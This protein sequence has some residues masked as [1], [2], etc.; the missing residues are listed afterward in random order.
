MYRLQIRCRCPRTW[1]T[2][3]ARSTSCHLTP[4]ASPLRKP[5]RHIISSG[6]AADRRA[7]FKYWAT[8]SASSMATSAALC[9]GEGQVSSSS[10][11]R[12]RRPHFTATRS[13]FESI[14]LSSCAALG[15]SAATCFIQIKQCTGV[16]SH[17]SSAPSHAGTASTDRRYIS[18]VDKAKHPFPTTYTLYHV[19]S[20][21][22]TVIFAYL[23]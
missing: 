8:C 6:A 4:R 18:R 22:P 15:C 10:S 3:A 21:S 20:H 5:Q 16:S 13:A 7:Y 23:L 11:M 12:G 1:R 14:T 2:P 19:P 9:A 17:S